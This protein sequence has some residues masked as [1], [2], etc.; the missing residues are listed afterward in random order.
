[1][2]LNKLEIKGFKSF[3]DKTVL[4]FP[5]KLTAIVG[6]NGSGKS[7]VTEAICFVLGRSR[8][9]R[10]ANLQELIYNG[11]ISDKPAEKAVVAV[12]LSDSQGNSFR[13]TRVVDREGRS[14][15]TLN[16]KRVTRTRIV[17]IVGDN[18]YNILLQDDVTRVIEMKPPERR[19][20]I[21]SLCGIA[22]YDEKKAKAIKELEKVEKLIS[23]THIV[24]GEKQGYMN[25]LKKERDEA[26]DYQET[27]EDVRKHQ[28]S[29]LS[30]NIK[31]LEKRNEKLDEEINELNGTKEADNNK[32]ADLRSRITQGTQ[33]LKRI[34]S[35]IIGKEEEK[36]R[37]RIIQLDGDIG[38]KEDYLA[39]LN[40]KL[41]A[42]AE[43]KTKKKVRKQMLEEE[44]RG[45]ATQLSS[46]A[47][48][49]ARLK[50][51]IEK[52]AL[53]SSEQKLE[54]EIDELRKRIYDIHA[55]AKTL[56]EL[57]NSDQRTL[58]DLRKEATAIS[59]NSEELAAAKR[60]VQGKLFVQK[61]KA[62]DGAGQLGLKKKE[63]ETLRSSI[64]KT[65]EDVSSIHIST[66]EKKANLQALEQASHGLKSAITAI[67]RIKDVVPGIHGPVFQLGGVS[68]KDYEIALQIAAG[69][70]MQNIVVENVDVAGKC[71]DYL[72]KK[73]VGRATFLPLD[74][75]RTDV[76]DK[77]PEGALGFARDFITADERYR[78]IFEYVFGNTLIVRTID[79]AKKIG[80]GAWRMVTLEGDLFEAS[81]AITGGHTRRIEIGF[82]NLEEQESEITQME[83]TAT[84]L[85]GELQKL[86][87]KEG[88]LRNG[89][90]KLEM[91]VADDRNGENRLSFEEKA[92]AAKENELKEY[93]VKLQNRIVELETACAQR[94]Q[95]LD[96]LKKEVDELEKHHG[97]LVKTRGGHDTS[98]LDRLKD[99]ARD[100]NIEEN[101]LR[102]RKDML[103][104]QT[105]EIEKEVE[106]LNAEEVQ[107]AGEKTKAE[108]A[109]RTLQEERTAVEKESARVINEIEQLIS[110]R[111]ETENQITAH[112]E[113]I[114]AIERSFERVNQDINERVIEKAKNDTQ[115]E[116]YNKEYEKYAGAPVLDKSMKDLKDDLDKLEAK[117]RQFGSINMRAI[118]TFEQVKK[119]YEE[120]F[121]K[122]A[123]LKAERQSIFD[124]MEKVEQRKYETFMKTFDV[125]KNNFERIFGKLSEGQ[126]TL[127]L[128]NPANISESGLLIRASP[129]G[130]KIMSLD[131]MSGGEKVLTSAGF[132]LAVQQYKPSDFYIID[133]LDA[134]LDKMNSIKLT[135]ML[136][137]SDTQ[138]IL[139]THNDAV[140]RHVGSV[141][142]VSMTNG[143]SQIVGVK[144]AA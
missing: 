141:I 85:E 117:L 138:F 17:D 32:I 84:Q 49:L 100:K 77:L 30:K 42:N 57:N 87:E 40:E 25:E 125:V 61:A 76:K 75:I 105:Q 24:L 132:L 15:Y 79:D 33:E 96:S 92:L 130:K 101:K 58:E 41:Q 45:I 56:R 66:A 74:K 102:E 120:T 34:N 103:E 89:I 131:A 4:E 39:L 10:A 31:S 97:R 106:G 68:N 5:D 144:L 127:M 20:V 111:G 50:T 72:R 13:I 95:T 37:Q 43:N 124:F 63:L 36:S 115:L 121:E 3:R 65:Q 108:K 86:F 140:L 64:Q 38:R 128:D 82:S 129:G 109:I 12:E 69:E 107:T 78:K 29:I 53:S 133:E 47:Q 88:A 94:D 21:D 93:L 54:N 62:S 1:M 16:D 83:S 142:G 136:G 51:D 110:R 118:E 60:D 126:G 2:R 80:V 143:V 98:V 59:G 26:V 8:G 90:A 99:S 6:P 114:G 55:Q 112:S 119:E 91:D 18:E 73:E 28:A 116:G 46:L 135:E 104:A 71:I 113:E 27:R 134:A 48:E 19:G 137:E 139:V 67:M 7:N 122:L 44:A 70:R 81:G 14:T 11:G 9:L 23:D 52:E 35:E 22:E 123:T